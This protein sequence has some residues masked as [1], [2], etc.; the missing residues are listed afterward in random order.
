MNAVGKYAILL[1]RGMTFGFMY[2]PKGCEY[3]WV[4]N[5]LKEA[6]QYD[7]IEEAQSAVDSLKKA[8]LENER[9]TGFRSDHPLEIRIVKI[10]TEEKV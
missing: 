1:R 6:F 7:K 4:T 5:D 8:T 3:Y 2:Q 9:L 10:E